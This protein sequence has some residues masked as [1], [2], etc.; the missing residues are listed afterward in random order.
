M[1]KN[2]WTIEVDFGLELPTFSRYFKD[3]AEAGIVLRTLV[4][5]MNKTGGFA[6]VTLMQSGKQISKYFYSPPVQSRRPI[7]ERNQDGIRQYPEFGRLINRP[8]EPVQRR[9]NAYPMF[10]FAEA[11]I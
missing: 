2:V 10:S 5:Q 6:S 4:T 11:E 7:P 3:A 8:S 9:S 1:A